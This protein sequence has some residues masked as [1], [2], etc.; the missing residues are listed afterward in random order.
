MNAKE[1]ITIRTATLD[2][3]PTI[4]ILYPYLFEVMHSLQPYYYRIRQQEMSFFKSIIV[5]T[6]AEILVAENEKYEMVALAILEKEDP[7]MDDPSYAKLI[8]L[9]VKGSYHEKEIGERL[10]DACSIWSKAKKLAY[11]ELDVLEENNEA[12]RLYKKKNYKFSSHIMR[13]EL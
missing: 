8:D 7:L 11:I 6:D 9:M 12:I 5:S 13:L 10:L 3:L 2:D 1:K 4:E